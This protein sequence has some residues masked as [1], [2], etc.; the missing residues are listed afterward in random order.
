ML[1]LKP[2]VLKKFPKLSNSKD[3]INLLFHKVLMEEH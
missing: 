3:I 1:N 2:E